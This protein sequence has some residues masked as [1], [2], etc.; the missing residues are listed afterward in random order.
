MEWLN[1]VM[2]EILKWLLDRFRARNQCPERF[3][4]EYRLAREW[5]RK[6]RL[7]SSEDDRRDALKDARIAIREAIR[8]GM[9]A[10]PDACVEEWFDAA[11][12]AEELEELEYAARAYREVARRRHSDLYVEATLRLT[13]LRAR[14][15]QN[16]EALKL[17][18]KILK[19]NPC[20]SEAI[21]LARELT[22]QEVNE[23]STG[24]D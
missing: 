16:A 11:A 4:K 10:A 19:S 7:A 22:R 3:L 5:H 8:S 1:I 24:G 14:Q 6:A 21:E 15:G 18:K 17:V 23:I 20:H 12:L 9:P 2:T 13:A